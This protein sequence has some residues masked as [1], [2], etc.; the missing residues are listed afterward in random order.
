[1][2]SAKIFRKPK[3]SAWELSLKLSEK[4]V[5][6]KR[7]SALKNIVNA[8]RVA[9]NAPFFADAKAA[10]IIRISTLIIKIRHKYLINAIKS[11][12]NKICDFL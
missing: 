11:K 2:R 3:V 12:I 9:F 1:M 5:N 6:V 7:Q 8:I 10:S 4:D